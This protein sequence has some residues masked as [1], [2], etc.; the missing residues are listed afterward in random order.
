MALTAIALVIQPV[1]A[2]APSATPIQ[3]DK[4]YGFS[5]VDGVCRAELDLGIGAGLLPQGAWLTVLQSALHA[6][7]GGVGVGLQDDVTITVPTGKL[8]LADADMV[9]T[10]D[11]AGKIS[12]L[13]GSASAPVPTFG[14]LGDWQFITPARLSVGYDRGDAL[15][16]LNAPLQADRHYFF[17]DAQAG[18]NFSSK[19]MTLTSEPGQRATVVVDLAQPLIFIDG[20]VTLH[21]DGQMAYVRQALGPL[22]NNSWMPLDLP[23]HQSVLVHLQGQVGREIEPKLLVAG[24]YRVDGGLV[25]KWL[26][27]DATPL[28]AHGEATIGPEGLALEGSARSAIQPEQLFDGGATAQLF[29]PFHAS[30]KASLTVGAGVASPAIGVDQEANAGVVGDASWLR[31]SSDAAVTGVQEGWSNLGTA[32]QS[33][34]AWMSQGVGTGWAYTQEQWCGLMG[35]CASDEA[36]TMP[37]ETPQDAPQD[38]PVASA[39]K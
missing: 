30:E 38:A 6:L 26:Q 24:E 34:Y 27:V 2:A 12:S 32:A 1:L 13:R 9:L 18:L 8:S 17:L 4:T 29:V 31:R 37:Q 33:S 16:D 20:Q 10:M 25:A 23:L 11:D 3:N 35:N 15:S 14:L 5:C 21:T 19:E 28:I 7:P 39:Q 22:A 36:M